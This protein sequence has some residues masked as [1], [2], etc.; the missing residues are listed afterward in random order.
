MKK[1]ILLAVSLFSML[2]FLLAISA[3]ADGIKKF[4]TDEFQSGDNITFVEGID[5]GAYYSSQNKGAGIDT[6]YDN[7]T[8]AR[9]VVK[10]SDGTY[11]TYPTYY[12]IRTSDDW[13]GDYQFIFCDRMNDMSGVTG[14]TY[15]KNSIIRIEYP[16]LAPNHNFGK[17]STNV[18]SVSNYKSLKY[19]YVS[20]QFKT[21]NKSFDGCTALETVE[22]AP[23]SQLTSVVQFTFRNCDSLEKLVLPNTVTT[24]QKEAIQSCDSLKELRLG[25]SLVTLKEKNSLNGIT[26][27]DVDVYLPKTV[28]GSVYDES[29][30]SSKSRV[31]FTGTK[32]QA[33]AFNF[34]TIYSYEEYLAAGSPKGKMIVYGYSE[35]VAFYNGNHDKTQISPCV[36]GCTKCSDKTVNHISDYEFTTVEYANGFTAGGEM[37]C[38]CSSEGCTFKI[39]ADMAPLFTCLGYSVAE[40]GKDGIDIG[41]KVDGEAISKYESVTGENVS[42]GIFAGL[43]SVIGE[44]DIFGTDGKAL[45]GVVSAD[46]TDTN[47]SIFEIKM[48]G[49]NEKQMEVSFAM[50]AYVCTTKEE[51]TEYSYLQISAPTDG[52]KYYFASYNDVLNLKNG[53]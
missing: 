42:Y 18:E 2:V 47:Y 12:F 29:W 46:M 21:L 30:F 24:L 32:E 35:C 33:E 3:S 22:F 49:F 25:A 10:N 28:D 53:N 31:F 40:N 52:A 4:E 38:A 6:L 23:N 48:V 9:I 20:S 26:G 16:E 7:S 19:V 50:G 5:L 17:L 34:A 36:F 44:N 37:V 45:A 1:K 41:Y 8:L 43:E 13:Q 11:T 39:V 51:K 14:E 27:I 15:D